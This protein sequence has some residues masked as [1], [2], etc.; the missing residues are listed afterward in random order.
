LGRKRTGLIDELSRRFHAGAE[1]IRKTSV[2][3]GSAP[4]EHRSQ[5]TDEFWTKHQENCMI[6]NSRRLCTRCRSI[7]TWADN[8][9]RDLGEIVWFGV[10]WIGLPQGRDKR[11]ALVNAVMKLQ[12][13]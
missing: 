11:S 10:S 1:K 6:N 9:K 2:R 12:V 13:S 3:M 5:F 7:G 4:T 8:I